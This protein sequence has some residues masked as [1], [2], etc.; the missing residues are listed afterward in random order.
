MTL[1]GRVLSRDGSQMLE[2]TQ[3]GPAAEPAMLG[4]QVANALLAR[5]AGELIRTSRG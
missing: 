2:D 4:G 3:A 1:T 5:G